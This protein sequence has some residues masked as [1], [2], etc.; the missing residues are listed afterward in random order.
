MYITSNNVWLNEEFKP[1][2]IEI[3]D[4]RIKSIS[5]GKNKNAKDYGDAHIIPGMIDIHTHGYGGGSS[6]DGD[7]DVIR[8]WV[9]YYPQE[10]VT[11]FLP[12]VMVRIEERIKSSLAA[13]ADVKDENLKGAEI[14]GTF[15][16]APFLDHNYC[17]TYDKYLL[18][19]PTVEHVKEYIACSRNTIRTISLAPEHD[20]DHEV[21]KYCVSQGI[22]VCLG[23]SSC[24]YEEAIKAIDD[25]AINVVHCFNCMAPLLSRDPHLPGAALTDDRVYSEVMADGIHVH[26]AV[27]NLVGRMKGKDR[28]ITITDSSNMKGLK[29]GFYHTDVRDITVC[30]DG[31]GRMPNGKIAGSMKTMIQNVQGLQEIGKL[32]LVTAINAATINPARMLGIDDVKGLIKEGYMADFAIYDDNYKIIQTYVHGQEM[33]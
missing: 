3:E 20:K 2:T 11:T 16:Q 14:H 18:G 9:K 24:S 8:R 29:P 4:D 13:I 12:G 1:A 19:K 17:G 10:G 5:L 7:P 31:V 33:L 25:G 32:P 28:L 6:T 21:I 15:L 30:D 23:F 22:K 26:P 27:M